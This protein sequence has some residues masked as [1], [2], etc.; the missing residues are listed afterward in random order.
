[1]IAWQT[2][3]GLGR[4]V[5]WLISF[6]VVG[7][8]AARAEQGVLVLQVQDFHRHAI[9]GLQMR[10]EGSPA[11]APTDKAGLAHLPLDRAVASG[12][13]VT[14]YLVNPQRDLAFLSPWDARTIVPP[15]DKAT[16][17]LVVLVAVAI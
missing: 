4:S 6:F 5:R 8:A 15:F 2:K 16:E 10:A 14:L 11:A 1:M 17:V 3:P 9:S 12:Q 13:W 7:M